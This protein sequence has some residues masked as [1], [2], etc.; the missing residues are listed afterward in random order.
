M[1][2]D[3]FG[4]AVPAFAPLRIQEA[5][6]G[7]FDFTNDANGL[8]GLKGSPALDGTALSEANFGALLLPGEGK[9]R[10]GAT[11]AHLPHGCT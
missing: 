10:F 9:P 2:D 11:P 6:L 7:M 4:S 3:R 8:F 1:D 5:S